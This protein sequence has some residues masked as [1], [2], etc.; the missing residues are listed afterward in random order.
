MKQ[1]SWRQVNKLEQR[2][3]TDKKG[4]L[5]HKNGK[6]PYILNL[7]LMPTSIIHL[8][9][10]YMYFWLQIVMEQSKISNV[11]RLQT[12]TLNCNALVIGDPNFLL[13]MRSMVSFRECRW[14]CVGVP[15][16]STSTTVAKPVTCTAQYAWRHPFVI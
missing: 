2:M 5:R 1:S 7:F 15:D 10:L 8:V 12:C 3:G 4:N 14:H 13:T 16:S 11:T 9:Y 6:L